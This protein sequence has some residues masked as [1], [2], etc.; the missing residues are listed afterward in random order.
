L[1]NSERQNEAG[2]FK[3]KGHEVAHLLIEL[4]MKFLTAIFQQP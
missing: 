4:P 2:S 1:A 3:S